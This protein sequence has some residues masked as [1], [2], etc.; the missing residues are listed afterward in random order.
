M[1]PEDAKGRCGAVAEALVFYGVEPHV[2]AEIGVRRGALSGALLA[3]YPDLL[4]YMVDSW[5]AAAPDSEYRASGDQIALVS[6]QNMD[7]A[8]AT[9]REAARFAKERAV[10]LKAESGDAADMLKD[11]V[12]DF[13][14]IDAEHTFDAVLR[15]LRLWVPKV[16]HGGIVG[17]H[18][19]YE[20]RPRFEK[21]MVPQAVRA[22]REEEGLRSAGRLC[23]ECYGCPQATR[24]GA[25]ATEIR[26][27]A[28][29]TWFFQKP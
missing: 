6:Q 4:L 19:W 21:F 2:G 26:L 7:K 20:N 3:R 5:R 25:T 24:S 12:L 29:T 27:G 13:V 28:E 15:D 8:E 10:V 23:S 1:T 16:R 18:D 11:E 14:F 22:F 9:A 17:G